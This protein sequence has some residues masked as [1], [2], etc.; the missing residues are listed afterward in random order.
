[1]RK[2]R[3]IHYLLISSKQIKIIAKIAVLVLPSKQT[4]ID[5]SNLW[6]FGYARLVYYVRR[7]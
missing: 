7:A 2:N 6:K 1:M 3:I 4:N 5:F